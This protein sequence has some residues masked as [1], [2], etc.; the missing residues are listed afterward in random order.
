V[1]AVQEI[2]RIDDEWWREPISRR[3]YRLLLE[4][5]SMCTIYRDLLHDSWY[6]QRA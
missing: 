6:E 1:T 2:W 5:G 3:Y 4:Q